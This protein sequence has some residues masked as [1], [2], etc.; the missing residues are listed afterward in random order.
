[1]NKEGIPFYNVV[2]P[3]FKHGEEIVKEI[4]E[5]PTYGKQFN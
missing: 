3:K 2:Y 4:A 5:P 1:M